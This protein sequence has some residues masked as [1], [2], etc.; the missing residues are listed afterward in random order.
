MVTRALKDVYL[1]VVRRINDVMKK[2]RIKIAIVA[3]ISVLIAGVLLVQFGRDE[4]SSPRSSTSDKKKI[5][6]KACG[7]IDEAETKKILGTDIEQINLSPNKKTFPSDPDDPAKMPSSCTYTDKKGDTLPTVVTVLPLDNDEIQDEMKGYS[8]DDHFLRAEE[9][10]GNA[11]KDSG[12]D[13]G[14]RYSRV[15][16]FYDNAMVTVSVDES[17]QNHIPALIELVEQKVQYENK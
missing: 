16:V 13:Q 1:V 4:N 8:S 6:K 7:L 17:R 3:L 9:Y 11:F 2:L 12:D 10:G 5:S 15:I 14:K